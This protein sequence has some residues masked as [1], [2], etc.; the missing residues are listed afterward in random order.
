MDQS[1]RD[2]DSVDVYMQFVNDVL[3]KLHGLF[4]NCLDFQSISPQLR[5]HNL[6]TDHQWQVIGKK[7]S[8][9]QQVDEFLKYLP[10]KGRNCLH[11]LMK[12]LQLSLDHAGHQDLLIELKKIVEKQTDDPTADILENGDPQDSDQVRSHVVQH[13]ACYYIMMICW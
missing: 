2:L 13:N 7:D 12:C 6:L 9:E 8:R 3:R 11:Q 4:R 1:L 10:H 5:S